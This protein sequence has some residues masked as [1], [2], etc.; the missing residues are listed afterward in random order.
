MRSDLKMKIRVDPPVLEKAAQGA[1]AAPHSLRLPNYVIPSRSEF[2][3]T[4]PTR[5]YLSGLPGPCA[6]KPCLS[7]DL[8]D[9]CAP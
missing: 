4:Q 5:R 6:F 9:P 2:E 7:A 8:T 3:Y 1:S